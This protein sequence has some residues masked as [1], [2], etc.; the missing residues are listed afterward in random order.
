M[1]IIPESIATTEDAVY[2]TS[3]I[4]VG[5]AD[6]APEHEAC[7]LSKE[8]KE[9]VAR[10]DLGGVSTIVGTA[11]SIADAVV[12]GCCNLLIRKLRHKNII[13]SIYRRKHKYMLI[14]TIAGQTAKIKTTNKADL[15][16]RLE[17]MSRVCA[18]R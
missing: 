18:I 5:F 8:F 11:D 1:N 10:A 13:A 2:G 9:F 14:F 17:L 3:Q 4:F 15:I 12:D 6:Q 7:I 16:Y